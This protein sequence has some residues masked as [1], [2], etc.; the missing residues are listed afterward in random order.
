MKSKLSII[1][2]LIALIGVISVWILW[3]C[4]SLKLSVIGL[5][6][7]IGVIVALL[8]LIFTVA[9]GYQII[10]AIEVKAKITDIEHRQDR[11]DAYYQNYIK[12]A[13]NLQAGISSSAAELYYAKGE[14][15]ESFVFYHSALY[16]AI[17]AD[18]ANQMGR[19]NQ[20]NNLLKH[21]WNSPVI[22]YKEGIEEVKNDAEKIRH[23]ISYRNCL[24]KD[25]ECMINLFFE[26][27][28][29]LGC[30]L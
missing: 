13:N 15:F 7:F 22:D 18:Q 28:R 26:K 17:C 6:T 23:T 8:A 10:N 16:F 11:I 2:S 20:L 9:V 14:L 1:L 25:Y 27:V 3:I 12:L 29:S 4:D 30:K 5:E 21:S 24:S 19:I